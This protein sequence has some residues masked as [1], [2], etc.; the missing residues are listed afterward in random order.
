MES[1][2]GAHHVSGST[3]VSGPKSGGRADRGRKAPFVQLRPSSASLAIFRF[4]NVTNFGAWLHLVG[5][6]PFGAFREALRPL[7]FVRVM[8]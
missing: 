4:R 7:R 2:P 3:P 5:L 6:P 8:S 1:L